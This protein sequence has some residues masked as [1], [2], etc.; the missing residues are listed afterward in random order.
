MYKLAFVIVTYNRSTM[1]SSL[2]KKAANQWKQYDS[3]AY[4]MD[5]SEDL[6]TK[7][8]VESLALSNVVYKSFPGTSILYRLIEGCAIADAKYICICGDSVTPVFKN[9]G[10]LFSALDKDYD[11]IDFTYRDPQKICQKEYKSIV[12]MYK[13]LTWDMTHMGNVFFRKESYKLFS[14]E[15]YY[16]K[17]GTDLF[18]QNAIY[19]DCF[20]NESF[21]GYFE[22]TPIISVYTKSDKKSW[23]DRTIE[24]GCYGW[25]DYVANSSDKYEL[26][27]KEVMLSH[28]T[29]SNLRFDR[30]YS[31]LIL[32]AKGIFDY[33]IYKKYEPYM[34][35]T[36][37]AN[38]HIVKI[39]S[40]L[41]QKALY[42]FYK[43]A[44]TIKSIYRRNND[45][46]KM[47]KGD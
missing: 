4:I 23:Y 7:E 36:V 15:E 41:P 43:F 10:Q 21:Y 11:L 47:G 8:A 34:A 24:V 25:Y 32:R 35:Y 27:K 6:K 29:Y 39:I 12:E 26:C 45:R 1:V 22:A 40:L 46:E 2:L 9:Y 33:T 28:G 16:K 30:L 31:F 19:F 5:G 38:L 18:A 20:K 13:E 37:A 17:Y 42:I 3:A 14:S 44:H